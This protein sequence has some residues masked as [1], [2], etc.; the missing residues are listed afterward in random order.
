MYIEYP[1]ELN[2]KGAEFYANNLVKKLNETFDDF[3]KQYGMKKN[4][5]L[6]LAFERIFESVFFA[7]KK[8]YIGRATWED[9][10]L[11]KPKLIIKGFELKRSDYSRAGKP[12]QENILNMILDGKTRPEIDCYIEKKKQDLMLITDYDDIVIPKPLN[13]PIHKYK[14]LG[15]H[16][17][18]IIY[19]NNYLNEN[20]TP[21]DKVKMLY[22]EAVKGKPSTDVICYKNKCPV[23]VKVNWKKMLEL[24][25]DNKRDHIYEILGW[26]TKNESKALGAWFK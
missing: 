25:I 5:Y 20:I 14:T 4:E 6:E 18:G 17:R 9:E 16:V 21:G 15:A 8:K 19:A 12:I 26:N 10:V 7:A 2:I 1:K 13:Q 24:I 3:V 22:V 11:E 23:E